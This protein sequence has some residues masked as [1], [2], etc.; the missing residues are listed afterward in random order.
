MVD[1]KNNIRE[2]TTKKN[3]IEKFLEK[4]TNIKNQ[5]DSYSPKADEMEEIKKVSKMLEQEKICYNTSIFNDFYSMK[6]KKNQFILKGHFYR[7]K[8][9]YICY[10]KEAFIHYLS[11]I[12]GKSKINKGEIY[13]SCFNDIKTKKISKILNH[14]EEL[15]FKDYPNLLIVI[16]FLKEKNKTSEKFFNEVEE[17]YLDYLYFKCFNFEF[18]EIVKEYNRGMMYLKTNFSIRKDW[19]ERTF[20]KFIVDEKE[21]Y[22]ERVEPDNMY[23][24][25][26]NSQFLYIK[27]REKQIK[28]YNPEERENLIGKIYSKKEIEKMKE[29]VMLVT[30]RLS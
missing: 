8:E 13:S 25:D 3:I 2:Y 15:Q 20:E 10:Y 26:I 21:I 6:N 11:Q 9:N 7:N 19:V 5:W 4:I 14:K 28:Y 22:V 30:K 24:M 17:Y 29:T 18:F 1:S 12:I 16:N 27:G 23:C